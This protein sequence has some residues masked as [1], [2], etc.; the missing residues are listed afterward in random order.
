[1]KL[2]TIAETYDGLSD[3]DQF[4]EKAIYWKDPNNNK[5]YT[6]GYYYNAERDPV[7]ELT[8]PE[9]SITTQNPNI[10]NYI[11]ILR[12]QA[13]ERIKD[14]PYAYLANFRFTPETLK[15]TQDVS[16]ITDYL[17]WELV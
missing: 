8:T 1:M 15:T 7:F 16:I 9:G 11:E 3:E 10:A 12:T 5:N 14:I 6:F 4:G 2:Y 13:L 17:I